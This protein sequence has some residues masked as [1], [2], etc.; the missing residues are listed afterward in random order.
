MMLT[1]AIPNTLM[2]SFDLTAV[3]LAFCVLMCR[4]Q[5]VLQKVDVS[6]SYSDICESLSVSKNT[7]IKLTKSLEKKGVLTITRGTDSKLASFVNSYT[8]T[9]EV[10][11]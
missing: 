5:V 1:T 10:L 11:S 8:F 2:D 6:I 9:L 3:E 7:V 4:K